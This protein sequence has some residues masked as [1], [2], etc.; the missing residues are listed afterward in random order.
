[1]LTNLAQVK[2]IAATYQILLGGIP[3][4]AGFDFLVKSNLESNFGAGAG[5]I[6]NDE[7]IFINVVNS[8]V[9]GNSAAA[10]T[11]A[12]L[13]TGATLADKIAAIYSKIIPLSKQSADGL[14]FLTRPEGLKFYQDVAKERGI[15]TESG[16]AIVALASLLKIA[17]DAKIGVG[18]PAN[19][20]VLSI[21]D[22]SATLP[23]TSAVVLPIETVD[24]SKFDGDDLLD[25]MVGFSGPPP[26]QLVGMAAIVGDPVIG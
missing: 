25:F 11:F 13:A 22:G 20:L 4:I 15:T 21:T 2:A 16:A 5:P 24:G 19:D 26:L 17:A 8:L 18:N 1:M 23:A 6:F 3:S 12:G 10:A 14:A 7:N 9:Q